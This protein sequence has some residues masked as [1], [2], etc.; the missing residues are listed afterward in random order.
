MA[1]SLLGL[2]SPLWEWTNKWNGQDEAMKKAVGVLDGFAGKVI[3]EKQKK[4]AGKPAGAAE[5]SAFEDY[6]SNPDMDLL[7]FFMGHAA[8]AGKELSFK[9]L[10][11]IVMNFLIAGGYSRL[12]GCIWLSCF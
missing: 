3:G 9:E 7:D 5:G 10:R 12:I 2:Y 1:D 8:D 11:D 6:A 4:R